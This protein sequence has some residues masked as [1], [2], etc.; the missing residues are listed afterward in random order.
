[1]ASPDLGEDTVLAEAEAEQ[2]VNQTPV[3]VIGASEGNSSTEM[4]LPSFLSL[5]TEQDSHST[6]RYV[7]MSQ[8]I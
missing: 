6:P 4:S 1:M 3:I 8:S 2:D 5:N 7:L